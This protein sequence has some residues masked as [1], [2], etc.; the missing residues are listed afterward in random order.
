M[1]NPLVGSRKLYVIFLHSVDQ[2]MTE[3]LS[4]YVNVCVGTFLLRG[5]G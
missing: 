3:P 2:R 1:S 5:I 4:E